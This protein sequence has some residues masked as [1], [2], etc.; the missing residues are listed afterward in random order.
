MDCSIFKNKR[1]N[2]WL[3]MGILRTLTQYINNKGNLASPDTALIPIT[4]NNA[5]F[6]F[7]GR[8]NNTG[9][10]M[11]TGWNG[12]KI[13]FKIIGTGLIQINC[14]VIDAETTSQTG[15]IIFIDENATGTLYTLTDQ[16]ETFTGTKSV[17][18]RIPNDGRIHNIEI[19]SALNGPPCFATTQQVIIN[20]LLIGSNGVLSNWSQGST[21]IQ[22]IGDSW[23]VSTNGWTRLMNSNLWKLYPVANTSYK[24]SDMNTDY[25]YDYSGQL[26]TTD[27]VVDAII[28]SSGV[29]DFVAGVTVPTFQTSLLSLIDKVQIK[30][31]GKPIFLVRVPNNGANLYGQYGTAMSNAVGLRTNVNYIDT[32]SLDASIT[33]VSGDIYHLNDQGKILMANFVNNAIDAVL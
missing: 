10:G 20:S 6:Q 19:Y 15:I 8:W 23:S 27:P 31:P 12:G 3:I 25:D 4:Y 26:N 21:T 32:S 13:V 1:I 2:Y 30:Q 7:L 14:S 18:L 24:L 28:I 29:N 5:N 11:W 16:T 17:T 9:T 33:F 22:C